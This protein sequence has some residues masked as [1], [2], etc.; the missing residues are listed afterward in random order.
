MQQLKIAV[1]NCHIF[2]LLSF[3][4][5]FPRGFL[6]FYLKY[7]PR[8]RR[9]IKTSSFECDCTLFYLLIKENEFKTVHWIAVGQGFDSDALMHF[10]YHS[11]SDPRVTLWDY[12]VCHVSRTDLIAFYLN[13][14][15]GSFL[16]W[17]KIY[18]LV[19][20]EIIA[21]RENGDARWWRLAAVFLFHYSDCF[22]ETCVIRRE[23][24]CLIVLSVG[25]KLL[26]IRKKIIDNMLIIH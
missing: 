20:V 25:Q 10:K 5:Y 6:Q 2:P 19:H 17:R 7:L 11:S 12:C 8:Q 14:L 16:P 9:L 24:W 4:N 1:Y 26:E 21:R 13:R 15:F 22:V 3:I 23:N 18:L